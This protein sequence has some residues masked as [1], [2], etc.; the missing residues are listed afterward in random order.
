MVLQIQNEIR[1][2]TT[3]NQQ[4]GWNSMFSF[5]HQQNEIKKIQQHGIIDLETQK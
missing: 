3:S 4:H 5:F 1:N 2:S